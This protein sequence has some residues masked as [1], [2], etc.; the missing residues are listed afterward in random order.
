VQHHH[1]KVD[2]FTLP[3]DDDVE[4]H[5]QRRSEGAQVAEHVILLSECLE[6]EWRLRDKHNASEE[7][8][9]DRGPEEA[10]RLPQKQERHDHDKHGRAKNDGGCV[11]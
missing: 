7:K 3:H 6:D 11:S 4:G 1:R 9:H 2:V 10:T 5:E 8:R